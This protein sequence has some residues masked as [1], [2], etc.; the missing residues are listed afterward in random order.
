[1]RRLHELLFR[2]RLM[3]YR[4]LTAVVHVDLV[5][6]TIPLYYR[7]NKST[8][9]KKRVV[10]HVRRPRSTDKQY[11]RSYLHLFTSIC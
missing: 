5:E 6:V 1:M 10:R 4:D 3:K 2:E 11:M 8:L 7:K 9:L